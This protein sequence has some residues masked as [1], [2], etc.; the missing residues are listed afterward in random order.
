LVERYK[1]K[2]LVI[3]HWLGPIRCRLDWCG[4]NPICVLPVWLCGTLIARKTAMTSSSV[5]GVFA[6]E[7]QSDSRAGT[8]RQ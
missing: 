2:Y 8:D 5:R 4:N 1:V 3:L 7:Y 6:H